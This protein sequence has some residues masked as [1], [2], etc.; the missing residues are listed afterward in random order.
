V[1]DAW[2]ACVG[3]VSVLNHAVQDFTVV[4][5][6]LWLLAADNQLLNVDLN[7]NF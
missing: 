5:D 3:N 2:L 4:H 1:L 7:D 6:Q